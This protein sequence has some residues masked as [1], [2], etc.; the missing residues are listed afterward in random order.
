MQNTIKKILPQGALN[1]YR[2]F[3]SANQI[4]SLPIKH[5]KTKNLLDKK[6][7]EMHTAFSDETIH[8][9]WL[10]KNKQIRALIPNIEK[11]GGINVGDRQAIFK[12][13]SFFKPKNVL[14][15]GT[16]I[17]LSTLYIASAIKEYNGHLTTVDIEDVNHK[18]GAWHSLGL[19]HS[20]QQYIEK[21]S[22]NDHVEFIESTSQTYLKQTEKKFDF[23]FLDGDHTAASVYNELSY[24]CNILN[25]NGLILLHDYYPD[26]KPL[27]PDG[28]IIYGPF[29]GTQKALKESAGLTLKP[30]GTLP[31][32][33]KQGVSQTSLAVVLK[34]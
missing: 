22:A 5:F 34:S 4:K 33:T 6:K 9:K 26:A 16:H 24:A 2:Y 25:H 30:L 14:E 19:D 7:F 15:I 28:N 31:W 21:I 23:I 17:G 12:I 27:F 11:Y 18:T 20:P 3:K 13:I 29:M 8:K 10:E 32:Q 1:Q